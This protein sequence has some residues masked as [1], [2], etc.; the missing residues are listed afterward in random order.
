MNRLIKS[1]AVAIAVTLPVVASASVEVKQIEEDKVSILYNK[2]AAT[3]DSY[4]AE[5]ERQV[6][7]VAEQVCGSQE[8]RLAGSLRQLQDNKECFATAVSS[9]LKEI[10]KS[11]MG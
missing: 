3:T 6:R 11:I 4:R 5:L 7:Q 2:A 9:A 8:L 1:F 10:E